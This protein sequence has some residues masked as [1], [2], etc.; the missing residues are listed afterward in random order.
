MFWN[1]PEKRQQALDILAKK[2][3]EIANVSAL[4]GLY[5]L[6][7]TGINP[8]YSYPIIGFDGLGNAHT[9]QLGGLFQ[10]I[11]QGAKNVTQTVANA[12]QKVT[13]ATGNAL[14]TAVQAVADNVQK[15][16]PVMVTARTAYRGLVALNFRGQATKMAN[17]LTT[18][19]GEEKLR[20]FWTSNL[21]GGNMADLISAINAGKGK[22]A[23]LGGT[24]LGEPV[25]I[26][27][28][29]A[30]ATPVLI[31]IEKVLDT[32]QSA[33]ETIKPVTD[34]ISKVQTIVNDGKAAY[35]SISNLLPNNN[36]GSSVALVSPPNGGEFVNPDPGIRTND[37]VNSGKSNTGLFVGLGVLAAAIIAFVATRGGSKKSLSGVPSITI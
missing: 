13:A 27:A 24:G 16:N 28:S 4:K 10:S 31:A 25:T 29:V 20:N 14:K 35:S 30:A 22:K 9:V 6:Q 15:I 34:T 32:I 17:A 7:G 19:E 18:R 12:A 26:A 1:D 8:I 21:I 37:P 33:Q 3:N 36:P 23:I 5:G 2:D 11:A